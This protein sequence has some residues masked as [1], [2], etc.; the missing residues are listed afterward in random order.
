MPARVSKH[1]VVAIIVVV[2]VLAVG[3]IATVIGVT[4]AGVRKRA[5]VCNLTLMDLQR[6]RRHR[7]I[8]RD[9]VPDSALPPGVVRVK[10]SNYPLVDIL[11][12]FLTPEEAQHLIS[13]A[14]NRFQ[15]SKVVDA[16]SGRRVK[17]NDRTSTTTFLARSETPTVKAVEQR[18]AQVAGLPESHL[19][20]LQVVRYKPGQFYKAHHDYLHGS[21]QEVQNNG[22]RT[23]TVFAY[24]NDLPPEEPGGGTRFP[25][26]QQTVRPKTGKAVLFH[27]VTPSGH[28]DPRTLH[29]GEP[30]QHATKYGLNIWFRDR[31]QV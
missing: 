3:V 23:L 15:R 29:S 10:V 25:H 14:E 20:R 5:H 21:T 17:N 26:L 28:V 22:Q 6:K 24:L 19:E 13:L 16:N 7:R 8:P 2:I 1:A 11:E 31:P 30:V 9:R 18:A 4:V 27:N 12:D